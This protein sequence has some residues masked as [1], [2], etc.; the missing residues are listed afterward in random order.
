MKEC[1]MDTPVATTTLAPAMAAAAAVVAEVLAGRSLDSAWGNGPARKRTRGAHPGAIQDLVYGALRQFGRGDFLLDRLLSRSGPPPLIRSLLLAAFHRLE[2]RPE[3][4]HTTVNQAVT[5]AAALSGGHF[6]SLVNAVL[7]NYLRRRAELDQAATGD[8]IARW[9]YPR[10]WI[11][12][13]KTDYPQRWED[14]LV[15]GNGH[16]PMT[17]RVNRRHCT[18]PAYVAE[19]A[20]ADIAARALDDT[21]VLLTKPCPV[22]RLPGFAEGRVSVQD[23]GAQRA[24]ALLDAGDGMRVLDACAAP[25]GKTAHLLERAR[26]DLLALD[27]DALRAN[28]IGENLK[29]LGL[30]ATVRAGDCRDPD[31]WWDGRPFDRILLDVPCSASGVVRRHPDIRWLRRDG[32]IKGFAARQA[33]IADAVWRTLAP[34]GKMLYCTCSLFAAENGEQLA[35]FAARHADAQRLPLDGAMEIQLT[36][37]AEHD[38]FYYALLQKHG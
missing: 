37:Q 26:L 11:E 14:I 22:D 38:G 28:R 24:A 7:R 12:R 34:G 5:A 35:A 17:L 31:N 33:E 23:W 19:L 8:E 30:A 21:A 25:G 27:A 18:A 1:G 29:R 15:A 6:K 36:P 13:L 16:P 3:D 32:D 2:A 9:R 10:W 20:A 4:A